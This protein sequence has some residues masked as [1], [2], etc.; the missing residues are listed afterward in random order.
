MS[1]LPRSMIVAV[2]AC[3]SVGCSPRDVSIEVGAPA[4]DIS[5]AGATREGV[6]PQPLRLQDFRGQTVVLAF[7]FKA[8]TPG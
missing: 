1:A 7:F 4:P 8:R 2:L 5:L 3:T 6:L